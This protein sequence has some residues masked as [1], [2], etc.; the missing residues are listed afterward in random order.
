MVTVGVR[1]LKQ[2]ASELVRMV[3]ETGQEV[4]VTYHGEIVAL[5]IPVKRVQ[6]ADEAKAWAKLDHL[7]AEIGARWP[8]GVSATKAVSE[9]RR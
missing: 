5:L 4:Q 1:E 6:K 8:K 2:Q 3:R 7:A 9:A